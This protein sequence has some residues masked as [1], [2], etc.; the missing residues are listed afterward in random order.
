M[1]IPSRFLRG[2]MPTLVSALALVLAC[3][4]RG[5][6]SEA[7]DGQ[8]GP[9]VD[10]DAAPRT[11]VGPVAKAPEPTK[12]GEGA[13]KGDE[14]K[15]DVSQPFGPT[16]SVGLDVTEG[17]W[18]SLDVS[19]DGKTIVFDLLGDLYAL[20][21]EGG[22][23]RPLTSGLAW[24][25]QPSF[26][27]DGRWIV[28]TSDRGGGDNIWMIPFGASG[29]AESE[30]T[31]PRQLTKESFRLVN[32]PS[33]SPDGQFVVAHKHFTAERSLGSGEMW[34]YH[35]TGG[36][37]VQL[38]EKPNDQQDVGEPAFSPDG[39]WLYYSQDV[40]PGPF[41]EYNKDPHQG[42]YAIMRRDLEEQRTE[43]L[44]SGPGGAVR[45]VPAPDGKR[46]AY[47]RRKGLRTVLFVYDLES[48]AEQAVMTG[49]DRDM[50][51]TWAIH[52]V[53][54]AFSWTPDGKGI[55][56]WAGG[57]LHRVDVTKHEAKPIPFRV[58]DTR[59][60]IEAVR[61][62]VQVHPEKFETKMLRW[63]TV[64]PTGGRVVF[65]ALGHLYVHDPS[66]NESRRLTRD[67]DV[68]EHYPAFSR[69]GKQLAFTTWDD[70]ALGSVRVVS[71]GGGKARTISPQPG[72]YAEPVW[73]PDGKTVV[74]RRGGGGYLRSGRWSRDP[75]LYALPASGAKK[76]ED[77]KLIVREG[78][79][80]Q[81]GAKSDRVFYVA[82]RRGGEGPGGKRKLVLESVD[83]QGHEER[84]HLSSEWAS[85][86][87]I[88]PD[89]RWVAFTERFHAYVRPFVATGKAVDVGPK[90]EDVPQVRLTRDAGND[91]H[92]S[93]DSST[94][95]WSLGPELYTRDLKDALAFM[96][97]APAE[98]PEPPTTGVSLAFEVTS[99][100]PKG[101]IALSG[102]RVITMKGQEVIERGTVLVEGNRIVAVGK[103]GE[104]RIPAGT[105]TIDVSGKT[106][107]PGLVDVHAHGSQG[108]DGFIP[109]QNWLH[110]AELALG[111]TTVHDPSNDTSTV[112]AAAEMARAG[113]LVAPRIFSTGTILYGAHTSFTAEV[114]G[115]DD[116]RRHLRRMKAVGAFSVKSY[117]QPR[118]EQR[119]QVLTAARELQMMVVPEGGSLF[120]HNMTMVV[121]GHTGVEHAIPVA[122]AYDDVEQLWGGTEVGYTPTLVVGY[123][124]LSGEYYW[125][126]HSNVWQ[127]EL[128]RRYVPPF[129]L[130]PRSR[131]R[132]LASRG[133]WN[134]I[135]IAR[136]AKHLLDAGVE[137]NIGAHG[138]REGLAAHW[139][140]WMLEQGGMS[141]HEA[142]RAATLHGARYLGLDEDIGSIEVGK[143][144][145]VVVI[146]GNPLEDI[147]KS[148]DVLYT[149]ING[150][151]YEAKTM[152]EIGNRERKREPLF[153]ER[154]GGSSARGGMTVDHGPGC[155][156]GLGRH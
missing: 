58:K 102:G 133:D 87:A 154:E 21:I 119:Q 104:V 30:G 115:L 108:T 155:S 83:L 124:G 7:P 5:Q 136:T 25:M 19:P 13:K 50:Q 44:L 4:S 36:G 64:S 80:P 29:D 146:D 26:S 31:E 35:V 100:V 28:F 12:E 39:R 14:P 72:H 52:G 75:G 46:L 40:T 11:R 152:N 88:S 144:A 147:R 138:Q 99:D 68:F 98:L 15:W 20:P 70:E 85:D 53:Y 116:A 90:S 94:L 18:M 37:G 156:C 9:M 95:H 112:F 63:V 3:K 101:R 76:P 130:Q 113:L 93:G 27:P 6:T 41:F 82:S 120:Q 149:M 60:V 55:V 79:H 42:I 16:K 43:T 128:L 151:V 118:R 17:T 142:L 129:V 86:F 77:M 23:A 34:L 62:P 109:Q 140:I 150:R 45:P 131:R 8:T 92:W 33:F 137:V 10:A 47:V 32:S 145:D 78:E 126:A 59:T 110:L 134:H 135:E 89:E 127:H 61:F 121:D 153:W 22:D 106:L 114:D 51:E 48:G 67:D 97:G 73:S 71:A 2:R 91:V 65:Q 125:Y 49:L 148:D 74:V 81:F 107:I 69:D 24:D 56:I 84:T 123:G 132:Q 66:T 141:P 57:K 111:V 143:L 105:K 1:F 38:T 54:P 122:R 139:E 96:E 117:N 103:Q